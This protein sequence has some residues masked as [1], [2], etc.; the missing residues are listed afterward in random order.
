VSETVTTKVASWASDLRF[1]QL[2][3]HLREWLG[4]RVA[5]SIGLIAV[6]HGSEPGRAVLDVCRPV[7][8]DA[9]LLFEETEVSASMAALA[10]GTLVHTFDYDDTYP[11]SVIHPSSVVVGG[12]G[13]GPATSSWRGA[14]PP[15]A[16][17]STLAAFIPPRCSGRS[18]QRS[19]PAPCRDAVSW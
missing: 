3:A 12:G 10:H 13:G 5:D 18:P 15:S 2:P 7:P 11:D 6:A 4:L 17:G 19:S 16:E 1:D 14:E 8:G 9:P